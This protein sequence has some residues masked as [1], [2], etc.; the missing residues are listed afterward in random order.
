MVRCAAIIIS[1]CEGQTVQ[2]SVRAIIGA[3]KV[4]YTAIDEQSRLM[5]QTEKGLKA[6]KKFDEKTTQRSKEK[7]AEIKG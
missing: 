4:E 3:L 6:T 1:G 2:Q 7:I 5:S